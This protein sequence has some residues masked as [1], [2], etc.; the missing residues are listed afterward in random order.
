VA[1]AAKQFSLPNWAACSETVL[2]A[3]LAA[4]NETVLAALPNWLPAAKQ[5]S[6]LN[7]AACSEPV[8]AADFYN[9]PPRQK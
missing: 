8:V 5:L 3:E 9:K 7:W 2:A 6:L 1:P 4:C